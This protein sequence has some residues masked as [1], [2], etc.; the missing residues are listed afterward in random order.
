MS[1]TRPFDWIGWPA[2]NGAGVALMALLP[3]LVV[4]CTAVEKRLAA[5]NVARIEMVEG[6]QQGTAGP[7]SWWAGD[8]QVISKENAEGAFDLYVFTLVLKNTLAA[9]VTL[10]RLEWNVSDLDVIRSSPYS[11]SGSWVIAAAGERRFTWPYSIVCPMLY[12]C[13]YSQ[14]VEPRWTFHFTGITAQGARV[15]VPITVT[16]PPQTLRTR[17]QASRELTLDPASAMV[18]E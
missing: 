15:D 6:H 1:A 3:I 14:T 12:S 18:T 16:L 8:M 7:I 4:G 17:F 9:P 5:M 10:T 11:Q 13:A 2:R